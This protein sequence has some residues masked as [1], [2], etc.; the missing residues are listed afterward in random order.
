MTLDDGKRKKSSTGAAELTRKGHSGAGGILPPP[1][2]PLPGFLGTHWWKVALAIVVLVAGA[3][4]LPHYLGP[5]PHL[6]G[7]APV[8]AVPNKEAGR[9]ATGVADAIAEVVPL[10]PAVPAHGLTYVE[11]VTGDS[12]AQGPLPLV[13]AVHGLGDRPD[14]FRKLFTRLPFE[15]RVIVPQGP[16]R[17][18]GGY[19]WFPTEIEDGKVTR[20]DHDAMRKSAQR[21]AWLAE[22]LEVRWPG[23]GKPV[24][25]GFSQGGILSFAVAAAHPEAVVAAVPMSGLWPQPLRPTGPLPAA[26]TRPVVVA[27]HGQDDKLVPLA[28]ARESV[29]ALEALGMEASLETFP[30]VAHRISAEMRARLFHL[31]KK[32]LLPEKVAYFTSAM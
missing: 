3:F 23:S 27:L 31:L 18:Y 1:A 19:S 13:I 24:I 26:A 7:E 30:A 12:E 6:A 17:Y 9:G 29:A 22:A 20:L 14:R 4:V 11:M 21:L 28:G 8:P 15:A 16:D 32:F 5:E 10:R 25:T 2:V